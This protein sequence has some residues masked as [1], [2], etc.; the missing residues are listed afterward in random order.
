MHRFRWPAK[1]P[2]CEALRMLLAEG[3][4]VANRWAG[5]ERVALSAGR[6]LITGVAAPLDG[7]VSEVVEVGAGEALPCVAAMATVAVP[8]SSPPARTVVSTA[9]HSSVPLANTMDASALGLAA[10]RSKH[11]SGSDLLRDTKPERPLG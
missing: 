7:H 10:R 4:A 5:D 1:L 2:H 9:L 6:R 8:A 3:F 11:L